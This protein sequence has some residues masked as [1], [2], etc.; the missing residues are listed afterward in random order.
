MQPL[1]IKGKVMDKQTKQIQEN[2]IITIR[3]KGKFEVENIEGKTR[4]DR[5]KLIVNK[6]V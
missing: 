3:G 1:N 6:F 5:I 4:N 2:D